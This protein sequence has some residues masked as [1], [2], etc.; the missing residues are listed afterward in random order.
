MFR[1]FITNRIK[2]YLWTVFQ[3]ITFY[4]PIV[5]LFFTE[6]GL[7]FTQVMLLQSWYTILVLVFNVP[8]SVWADMVSRKK[9][10]IIATFL[11]VIGYSIYGSGKSFAVFLMAETLLG[12]SVSLLSGVAQAYFYEMLTPEEKKKD[13]QYF[14][15]LV[16]V[17]LIAGVIGNLS[18]SVIASQFGNRMTFWMSS[19]T[20]LVAFVLSLMLK[21]DKRIQQVSELSLSQR[22]EKYMTKVKNGFNHLKNQK[23]LLFLV[24]QNGFI[25]QIFRINFFYT[26]GKLTDIGVPVA[27]FGLFYAGLNILGAV[28]VKLAPWIE[29][30]IGIWNSIH[31]TGILIAMG[32][33]F[34]GNNSNIIIIITIFILINMIN[35][36]RN[37]LFSSYFNRLISNEERATVLSFMA[38]FNSLIYMT[39]SPI[40]GFV[41]D[42]IAL[43]SVF[44]FFGVIIILAVIVFRIPK[45]NI[46]VI[47]GLKEL[48]GG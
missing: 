23:V 17:S 33:F 47:E 8:S 45:N 18:G 46:K 26:Q 2:F 43:D 24:I 3:V 41:A 38:L 36:W 14:A 10:L 34:I 35:Y 6:N 1:K 42:K 30:K 27:Y 7:S 31:L 9:V 16:T 44:I 13:K 20:A 21:E 40:M 22:Y 11:N 12:F 32:F 48:C 39:L 19:F 29:K 25:G 28:V 15:S 37:P 5:T 4:P